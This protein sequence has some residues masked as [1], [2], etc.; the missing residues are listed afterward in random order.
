MY[1]SV[2]YIY[3]VFRKCM[4]KNCHNKD[5]P[6]LVSYNHLL[7]LS[8]RTVLGSSL[9]RYVDVLIEVGT[10]STNPRDR[11]VYSGSP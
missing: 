4:P 3:R 7:I 9:S 10:S 2:Q 6:F 8:L 11:H 5:S 1:E